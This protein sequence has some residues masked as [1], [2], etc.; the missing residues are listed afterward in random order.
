MDDKTQ[1][2]MDS[3]GDEI[4]NVHLGVDK[5]Y[6][7]ETPTGDV[8]VSSSGTSEGAVHVGGSGSS[9]PVGKEGYYVRVKTDKAALNAVPR[10][11]DLDGTSAKTNP[12]SRG[13]KP[14]PQ[15]KTY[16]LSGKTPK[17]VVMNSIAQEFAKNFGVELNKK[18][19][20]LSEMHRENL[21]HHDVTEKFFTAALQ[22]LG[23][24]AANSGNK[25]MAT[26]FSDM[27]NQV[28]KF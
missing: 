28:A 13:T 7:G 11:E 5:N 17:G 27:V 23:T 15:D 6:Y 1:R 12:F 14:S 10:K 2:L 9:E 18:L 24:I 8:S 22:M 20:I 21:R 3:A 19:D 26:K 4:A 16:D 25:A